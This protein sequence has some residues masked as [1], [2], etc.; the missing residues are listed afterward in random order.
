MTAILPNKH[1]LIVRF[2]KKKQREKKEKKGNIFLPPQFLYM[3]YYLQYGE[4]TAIGSVIAETFPFI[5]VGDTALVHH[6]VEYNDLM[7]VHTDEEGNE[8]RSV[9]ATPHK[10]DHDMCSQVYAIIKKETGELMPFDTFLFIDNSSLKPLQKEITSS[11]IYI[12]DYRN[13]EAYYAR[14]QEDYT[15]H[16]KSL[17]KTIMSPHDI[18]LKEGVAKQMDNIE[19]Q[20]SKLAEL[21]SA[22]KKVNATVMY[23]NEDITGIAPGE[24]IMVDRDTLYPLSIGDVSYF[25][26]RSE[27]VEK[28]DLVFN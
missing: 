21:S 16:R 3:E 5:E 28:Y 23:S 22:P 24:T 6:I 14:V 9:N 13:D 27:F 1:G 15:A 11:L 20:Q 25:I 7:C 2:D 17:E 4:I 19:L 12:P 10:L 8:Y 26:I 18:R